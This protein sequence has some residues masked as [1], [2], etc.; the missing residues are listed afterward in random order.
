MS[1]ELQPEVLL[2][3]IAL[4]ASRL[5]GQLFSILMA[6]FVHEAAHCLAIYLC[7]GKIRKFSLGLTG[8]VIETGML[9]YSREL[10]CAMA[11]PLAG[12]SLTLFRSQYPWLAF[13]GWVQSVYN[14]LPLYP[15]DGGRALRCALLLWLP[16]ERAEQVLALSC[17]FCCCLL[18]AAG[19]ILF[20][21]FRLGPMPLLL[22]GCIVFRFWQ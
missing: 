3:W 14:L 10:L 21:V 18:L 17:R 9:P 5:R 6:G 11:G 15:L 4:G 7:G 8:A 12:F 19:G 22:A 13:W 2:L 16:L 20:A 1:F